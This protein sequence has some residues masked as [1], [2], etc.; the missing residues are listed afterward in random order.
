MSEIVI[1]SRL[2]IPA[3][4]GNIISRERLNTLIHNNIN[5]KLIFIEAP[6][7][8]G[9][10]TL[11]ID[12]LNLHKHEYAWFSVPE[13]TQD[14]YSFINYLTDSLSRINPEFGKT[15]A[16]IIDSSRQS[17]D[18]KNDRKDI[19]ESVTGTFIND[20]LVS[21]QDDTILVIDDVHNIKSGWAAETFNLLLENL[22]MRLHLF[23]I[24]REKPVFN[25]VRLNSKRSIKE[26]KKQD[27]LF[28]EDETKKL[29]YLSGNK[30]NTTAERVYNKL[31]GWVTG[32]HLLLQAKKFE[33]DE[34]NLDFSYIPDIL[35]KFFASEIFDNLDEN[36]QD[37]L[38]KTSLLDDFSYGIC[39]NILGIK[40]AGTIIEE[41]YNRNIFIDLK[42][43]ETIPSY[44]Y[45]SLFKEFLLMKLNL[46]KSKE[47]IRSIYDRIADFYDQ[48]GEVDNQIDFRIKSGSC[49]RAAELIKANFETLFNNG[50]HEKLWK[51][52]N[53]LPD[54]IKNQNACIKFYIGKLYYFYL[55]ELDPALEYIS[56]SIKLG[57]KKDKNFII[58]ALI[59]KTKILVY[60]GRIDEALLTVNHML[61]MKTGKENK[62]RIYYSASTVYYSAVDYDKCL[63]ML[64]KTLKI[65]EECLIPGFDVNV[66]SLIGNIYL[67]RGE[68]IKA[69]YYLELVADK[70]SNVYK[71][72]FALTNLAELYSYTGRYEAAKVYLDRAGYI[73][74]TFPSTYHEIYILLGEG[75]LRFECGDYEEAIQIHKKVNAMSVK[76][77]YNY[78]I[79]FSNIVIALCNYYLGKESLSEKHLK[80]AGS[81]TAKGLEYR[82]NELK[83]INVLLLKRKFSIKNTKKMERDLL[84]AL[85]YNKQ[86]KF[87][88]DT[89]RILFH[90]AHYYLLSGK[91]DDAKHYLLDAMKL[92]SG[93]DYLSFLEREYQHNRDIFD[94]AAV[95][96]IGK[97]TILVIHLNNNEKRSLKWISAPARQRIQ[98]SLSNLWDIEMEAFGNLQFKIRGQVVPDSTWSRK[99]CKMILAW[100]ILNKEKRI[101]K[102]IIIDR[103]F[104]ELSAESAENI[105]HQIIHNIRSVI[106]VIVGKK[107]F[108]GQN[109]PEFV[110][111]DHK[112][113]YMNP[114]FNY[115]SD[116]ERLDRINEAINK[117]RDTEEIK[118]LISEA[119]IIYKGNL[120]TKFDESW[121]KEL[122]NQYSE[123]FEL[124]IQKGAG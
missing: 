92:A 84:A 77:N 109:I 43:D 41:L 85:K 10:T 49:N 20:F 32:I 69:C 15:T 3:L 104:G 72:L 65:N 56:L 64:N 67:A 8:Y 48:C 112:N 107:G 123:K 81:V 47:E 55:G 117:C 30:S 118:E 59:E 94:F 40:S 66:N 18:F 54:V 89:A 2:E 108:T 88:Y 61:K 46:L 12:Y 87:Y 62:V 29:L 116:V 111:Y 4:P 21:F 63:E 44:K 74:K 106:K 36:V 91:Y 90:T 11:V 37:F 99:K 60:L 9:K 6:A 105:F 16:Q 68:F 82:V 22:P 80:I 24:S 31:N 19:I 25:T 39:N 86:N 102:E 34:M 124:I 100:L 113:L 121:C 78:Y 76:A 103:F 14:F 122:R 5:K 96:D 50:K 119:K 53:G 97:D 42:P 33:N 7:G 98:R 79:Y 75:F 26:I 1:K 58:T 115:I 52:L 114:D 95:N 38:L 13:N 110:I 73:L 45:Q 27:I 83:F 28:N 101:N 17:L 51:W 23:I 120:F 70:L 93:N 35:Y 71:R 57:G